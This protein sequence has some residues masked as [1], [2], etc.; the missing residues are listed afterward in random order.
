MTE[1]EFLSFDNYVDRDFEN[2]DWIVVARSEDIDSWKEHE[3]TLSRLIEN[4]DKKINKI[5]AR[6][7]WEVHQQFGLPEF[8][9]WDGEVNYSTNNITD[10]QGIEIEFFT[11][12]R[13]FDEPEPP[14]LE[15]I[16]NFIFYHNLLFVQ[17]KNHYIEQ[18]SGD[19]VVEITQNQIM[20]RNRYL[21]DYLAARNM[22]LVRYHDHRRRVD[23][24]ILEIIG[25]EREEIAK[26]NKSRNYSIVLAQHDFPNIRTYSRLLGKDI[27]KPYDEPLHQN[28]SDIKGEEKKSESFI[29]G[30]GNS[31]RIIEKNCKQ[32]GEPLEFLQTV[33]FNKEVLKKYYDNPSKYTVNRD[34]LFRGHLWGIPYWIKNDRVHVHLGDLYM[35][36]HDEQIY[37]KSFNVEPHEPPTKSKLDEIIEN[38]F[39]GEDPIHQ[40]LRIY[41]QLNKMFEGRYGFKLFKELSQENK[42]VLDSLHSLT[43]NEQ[44]ELEEQMISLAKIFVESINKKELLKIL[45]WVPEDEDKQKSIIHLEKMLVENLSYDQFN[46]RTISNAFKTIQMLRSAYS[47]HLVSSKFNKILEK[48]G[49]SNLSNE[50][51]SKTV[52]L[53]LYGSLR[54]ILFRI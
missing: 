22:V 49:L 2:E 19:V 16:Q 45:K 23:K 51:L 18:Q 29:V 39:D 6:Y 31:G 25:K 54:N 28:Y 26:K 41:E 21:R 30:R 33:S 10:W 47:A 4:D 5:L 8:S 24:P 46:A 15:L 48:L 32:D 11:L 12:I 1:K 27:I 9:G 52:I 3:F 7:E 38:E 36:P 17:D 35:I 37:W 44:K 53:Q 13:Y 42:H 14:K 50:E 34:R 40:L 20:I 43:S